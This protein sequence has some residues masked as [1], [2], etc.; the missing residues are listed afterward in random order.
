[1]VMMFLLFIVFVCGFIEIIWMFNEVLYMN[2]FEMVVE[3]LLIDILI[4]IVLVI[5]VLVM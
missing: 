1:M 2:L 3:L 5:C 4:E